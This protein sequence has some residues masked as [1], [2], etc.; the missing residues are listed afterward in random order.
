MTSRLK[1]YGQ[2]SVVTAILPQAMGGRVLDK[3]FAAGDPNAL[4]INARGTLRR[5]RWYQGLL[6]MISPEKDYLQFIVPDRE[7]ERVMEAIV[8]AGH[9]HL[10]GAGAVFAIPCDDFA[11]TVDVRL[12]SHVEP[13]GHEVEAPRAL[14][15]NLTAI[16]CV[17]RNDDTEPVARAAMNAGAHGPIVC[18]SEGTGL[19]GRI[20]WLRITRRNDKEMLLVIVDNAD[21]VVV[22]DAMVAAGALDA[23]GR[24][25]LF[26]MPIQTGL[27]NIGSTFGTR[28]AASIPQI[29]AA[30][31]EIKGGAQWRDRRVSELLGAGKSAGLNLFGK[32]RARPYLSGQCCLSLVVS[33]RHADSIVAAAVAAGAPGAN[34]CYGRLI[35]AGASMRTS[36][37][38]RINRERALVRIVLHESSRDEVWGAVEAACLE[39]GTN[40]FVMF[41]QQV[42]R[43]VTYIPEAQGDAEPG[44]YESRSQ[45]D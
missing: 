37:G 36:A 12:W 1:R 16:Y 7:V 4:L 45:K 26:R 39:L 15:E 5:D 25:F 6:P 35:E 28:Y 30:I 22:S 2:V 3:V 19:R 38:I 9:L 44:A 32:V 14:R 40:E 18:Y 23:P 11:A 41:S 33:R 34:L 10:P 42:T 29:I 31:D 21:A 27:I 20:G 43:A 24:G 13:D 17:V 8:D